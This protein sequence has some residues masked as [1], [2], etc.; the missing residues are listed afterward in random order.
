V[1][2]DVAPPV[3]NA[4]IGSAIRQARRVAGLS[5]VELSTRS[6]LSQPHLSQLEN[7]RVSPSISALYKLAS[8]LDVGPE[9]LLPRIG[10]EGVQVTRA[11][12][13]EYNPAN[14]APNAAQS[15]LIAGAPGRLLEAHELCVEPGED[16]GGWLDHPGED[17]VFV[18]SGEL[19]VDLGEGRSEQL[20]AGDAIWY[21]AR[22]PH[23]W[24]LHGR[25]RLRMIA[26]NGRERVR[27]S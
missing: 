12:E 2:D 15:R 10:E 21:S 20:G 9:D 11:S 19:I 14:E 17:F 16:M 4:A 8:A 1:S 6:G 13:G 24:R 25:R 27:P 26:V 23:R 18:I 3:L 7:G 22:Q 5:L